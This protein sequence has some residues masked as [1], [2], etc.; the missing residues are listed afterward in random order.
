MKRKFAFFTALYLVVA[1]A[2]LQA[3]TSKSNKLFID[4]HLLHPG[5]VTATDVAAAHAK[6]LAVQAKHGVQFLKYWVDEKGGTVYCLSSAPDSAHIADAHNEA[7]GLLPQ[8]V[9]KVTDGVAATAL[10][11]VPYFLDIHNLGAGNVTA[12]AV[13]NA[14]KKD[15]A[16]QKKNKVNFINYWVC[17]EKGIVFCLSQTTNKTK[18]TDT[19]K[20]AHGLIPAMVVPVV[21]GQ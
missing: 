10:P 14:H 16:V 18:V 1:L 3:Q 11:G 7:H 19:H 13:A 21:Q 12:A 8:Q 5:S 9:Y 6:D 20:A 15:L 2:N 17:E 4:V